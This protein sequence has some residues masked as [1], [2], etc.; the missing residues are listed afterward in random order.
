MSLNDCVGLYSIGQPLAIKRHRR[1]PLPVA[2][3]TGL[4]RADPIGDTGAMDTSLILC[5][6][7]GGSGSRARLVDADGTAVAEATGGPCN[8]T[9]D[10]AAAVAAISELW[11]DTAG[12][13]GI[14]PADTDRHHLAIGAAGLVMPQARS[15]FAEAL[16]AFG[17]TTIVTDGY[18]ALIGAGGGLPCCLIAMGTGAVGHRLMADGRSFQRDGWSWLGGDR[19]SGAWIGRQ[20]IEHALMVRDGIIPGGDLATAIDQAIGTSEGAA[21]AFLS[22]LTPER[23]A[24]LAPLVVD[25]SQAGDTAASN[26]LQRAGANAAALVRCLD[27]APD[28]PVYLVGG[29]ADILRDRI[30]ARIGRRFDAPQGDTMH[31]CF[32]IASGQ[33]PDEVQIADSL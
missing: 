5:V 23:A 8:P 32:L 29:L 18:A 22:K 6:D 12:Q 9:T 19:G 16:P 17:S 15:A 7:G 20:A 2:R 21:L 30:E 3:R 27:P 10:L 11:R 13:A 26:I 28:E 33:A 25:A 1:H 31:G 14:D 24:A 4:A